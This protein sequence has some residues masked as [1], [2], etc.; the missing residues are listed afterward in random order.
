MNSLIE[1]A[2]ST[3]MRPI[4]ALV[5]NASVFPE[6]TLASVSRESFMRCLLVN[7]WA[8]LALCRAFAAQASRGHVVNML[9]EKTDGYRF[10]HV[11]YQASKQVLALLTRM[12]A[13]ELAPRIAANAVAPGLVLSPRGSGQAEDWLERRARAVA[14]LGRPG[15]PEDVAEAIVFLLGSEYLTGQIIYV[16]GGSHLLEP[17]DEPDPTLEDWR[18]GASSASATRNGERSRTSL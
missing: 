11:A 15:R 6:D 8:P 4:D 5:N 17:T 1:R 10:S 14:P 2:C 12:V 16:D 18:F 9:D 13:L 3:A 7:S